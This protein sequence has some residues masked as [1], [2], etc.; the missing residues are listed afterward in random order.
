MAQLTGSHWACTPEAL[1]AHGQML[2]GYAERGAAHVAVNSKRIVAL[3]HKAQHSS[4][5][6][7]MMDECFD[8]STD[9]HIRPITDVGVLPVRGLL[10]SRA[11]WWFTGYDILEAAGD[12][13]VAAGVKAIVMPIGSPGGACHG[14]NIM[15]SA[16]RRWRESVPVYTVA[17][18]DVASA[19]TAILAQGTSAFG[20]DGTTIGH[21][22]TWSDW[23]DVTGNMREAKVRHGYISA[24]RLKTFFAGDDTEISQEAQDA[25]RLEVQGPIIENFYSLLLDDVA[26][27]RGDRYT[28]EQ[29][30][31]SEAQ[32][33]PGMAA[34]AEG[35][36]DG[37]ATAKQLIQTLEASIVAA[38]SEALR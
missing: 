25:L 35:L 4:G 28:R 31:A 8:P 12:A 33:Y 22:G 20:H 17:D 10:L 7:G 27:G 34:K 23:W 19:A 15:C 6:W 30:K 24:G 32:I 11:F 3:A 36:I 5:V 2:R 38:N 21:I 9:P 14:L 18:H 37:K 29:A 13:M 26:A 16:I 1:Q